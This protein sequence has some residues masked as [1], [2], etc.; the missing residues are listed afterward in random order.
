MRTFK[1]QPGASLLTML[2]LVA[3]VGSL[4]LSGARALTESSRGAAVLSTRSE[5]YQV[6]LSGIY[7][8]LYYQTSGLNLLE[9]E[10]GTIVDRTVSTN[11][12][13]YPAR[14]GYTR[15]SD[16]LCTIP[17]VAETVAS[18]GTHDKTCPWYELAI[19]NRAAYGTGG[20][21][22]SAF[23]LSSL[24]FP[25]NTPV[26]VPLR[27]TGAFFSIANDPSINLV[28][29]FYCTSNNVATCGGPPNWS[30]SAGPGG[31]IQPLNDLSIRYIR[32]TVQYTVP[33]ATPITFLTLTATPAQTVMGSGYSIIES[34]G[35][36]GETR[37]R[38][39]YTNRGGIPYLAETNG[40]FDQ[41]G[42][43]TR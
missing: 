43:F 32:L 27:S 34:V 25:P 2:L 15:D 24:D 38:L 29:W 31:A 9:G 5:A 19:R 37:V 20:G 3:V 1:P 8:G 42:I 23:K 21:P 16:G 22:V 30:G 18:S 10:Y 39:V 14:R 12:S 11:Y 36:S 35:R 13:L 6:A 7:E 41:Y 17:T 4:V 28:S 33:P 40:V 26:M